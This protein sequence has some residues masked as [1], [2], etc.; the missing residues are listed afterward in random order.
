MMDS[1]E[2]SRCVS[3]YLEKYKPNKLSRNVISKD[4]DCVEAVKVDSCKIL[5]WD[6][7]PVDA[8]RSR[9]KRIEISSFRGDYRDPFRDELC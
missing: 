7:C 5:T 9:P 6:M 1:E 3:L 2:W 8:S 4:E